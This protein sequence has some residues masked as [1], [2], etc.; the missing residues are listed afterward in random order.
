MLLPLS[1][2]YRAAINGKPASDSG[3]QT[4]SAKGPDW[5]SVLRSYPNGGQEAF[6]SLPD[7]IVIT[8]ND[9]PAA[10]LKGAKTVDSFVAIEKPHQTFKTY[11]QGG[12]ASYRYGQKQW[13]RSDHGADL[14]LKTSWVNLADSIGYVGVDLS[15]SSPLMVLPKP[16]V[17]GALSLYHVSNPRDSLRFMTIIFPNQAHTQ[18]RAMAAQVKADYADGVMTCRAPGYFVWANFSAQEK[19]VPLPA[20]VWQKGPLKA[21]PNAIGILHRGKEDKNWNRLE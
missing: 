20:D 19:A 10:A 2:D 3:A 11:F 18:T 17:R 12:D 16:G 21:A 15:Q 5:F 4:I 6:V 1:G 8:M 7:E 9:L 14:E 13:D